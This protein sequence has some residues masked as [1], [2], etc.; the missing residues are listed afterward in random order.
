[1]RRVL[2]LIPFLM[3]A[4]A[5]A[6]EPLKVSKG[7]WYAT[8]DVYFD[9]SMDGEKVDIPS[10][11]DIIDECWATDADVT[12]DE[13]M[14]SV[15]G[16]CR[17]TDSRTREHAFDMNLACD[18]DGTPMIGTASFAVSKGGDSF[19]GRIHLAGK[20]EGWP[21]E[22]EGVLLGHKTGACTGQN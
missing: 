14:A 15:M 6:A 9:F 16:E 11:H 3:I 18:F 12:I 2:A 20:V 19:Y 7:N 13:S 1:M 17:A 22:A 10:E 8:S 4:G 5:A 21:I